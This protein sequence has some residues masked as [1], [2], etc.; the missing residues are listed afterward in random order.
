MQNWSPYS[1]F[2]T[3]LA[4]GFGVSF[5][6]MPSAMVKNRCETYLVS[7]KVATS[8]VLKPPFQPAVEKVVFKD[9]EQRTVQQEKETEKVET[10]D[11]EAPKRRHHRR[12]RRHWRR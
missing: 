6:T 9:P 11:E 3:G 12:H 5:A 7:K 1:I 4:V 10:K 8:Y 2:T